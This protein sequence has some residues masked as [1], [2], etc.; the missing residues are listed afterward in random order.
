MADRAK[1]PTLFLWITEKANTKNRTRAG[2][3]WESEY[4]GYTIKLN[5]GIVIDAR[6]AETCYLTLKA[7]MT[8]E[9]RADWLAGK[10]VGSKPEDDDVP[11]S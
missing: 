7:P 11:I 6:L 9:E 4:G 1:K 10:G 5:P 2:A 8:E 3:A